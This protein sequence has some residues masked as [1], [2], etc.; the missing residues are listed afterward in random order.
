L[1]GTIAAT[2][3]SP[4]SHAKGDATRVNLLDPLSA[5]L[6]GTGWSVAGEIATK[7]AGTGSPFRDNTLAAMT[8]VPY[9]FGYT[10]TRTAGTLNPYTTAPIVNGSSISASG[11]YLGTT[12]PSAGATVFGFY[13]D[14]AFAGT[15]TD[16]VFFLETAA[17]HPQGVFQYWLRARN[18]E[19]VPG[20]LSGPFTV[21]VY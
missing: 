13:G 8:A 4:G 14:A 2:P 20:P 11:T 16:V 18:A 15:V 10:A 19:G 21:T 3:G 7:T 1:P 5:W 12:T 17:C 9:R 6:L